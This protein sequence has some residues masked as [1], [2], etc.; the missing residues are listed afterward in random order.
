M[1]ADA[2]P[3][4]CAVILAGGKARRLGG[5]DKGLLQLA[6][7]PL[8]AWVADRLRGQVAEIL[9]NANRNF[10]RYAALG[11]TVV[12]DN[13]PDQPGP[14]AGV[15]AAAPATKQPWLLC[16]PC[17]VPFLPRD[18]VPRLYQQALAS[19]VGLLRAADATGTHFAVMLIHRDLLADLQTFVEAGGRKVQSWQAK[20]AN[21]TVFF[22]EDQNAFINVNTPEDWQHAQRLAE[23]HTDLAQLNATKHT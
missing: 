15:L 9:I 7:R 6:Q 10:Q 14:L 22:S 21:E 12:P 17:D 2:P 1:S 11:C 18:L 16:V 13:L 19:K 4:V 20:H 23:L 5:E 8:V 3:P